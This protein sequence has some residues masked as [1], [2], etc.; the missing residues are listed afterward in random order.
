MGNEWIRSA[1]R[2]PEPG[3]RVYLLA[4]QCGNGS[5][6]YQLGTM[7]EDGR[8]VSYAECDHGTVYTHWR[9]FDEPSHA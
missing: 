8:F 4:Y 2:L 6:C 9:E 7:W 3:P 5:W 1:D